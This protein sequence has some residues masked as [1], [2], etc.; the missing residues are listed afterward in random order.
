MIYVLRDGKQDAPYT[1][2]EAQGYLDQ[3]LLDL[4]QLAWCEGLTD[5]GSS[6]ECARLYLA[7]GGASAT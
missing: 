3:Q 4:G 5:L 2:S 1:L 6:V 7:R